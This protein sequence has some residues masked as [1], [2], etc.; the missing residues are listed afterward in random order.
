MTN[1]V[2]E[3]STNISHQHLVTAVNFQ[4]DF[5]VSQ[6][7]MFSLD[8]QISHVMKPDINY[9]ESRSYRI[10]TRTLY[11]DTCRNKNALNFEKFIVV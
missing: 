2:G 9:L 8:F 6:N 10:S 4:E 3:L 5:T 7:E 11:H 1:A